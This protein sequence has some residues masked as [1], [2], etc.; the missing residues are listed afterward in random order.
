MFVIWIKGY[1][2]IKMN[3]IIMPSGYKSFDQKKK[4]Q[5]WL[6]GWI[7][8]LTGIGEN[9]LW[10]IKQSFYLLSPLMPQRLETLLFTVVLSVV[11]KIRN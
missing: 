2:H 5:K 8:K 7:N 1:S 4:W 3:D 6:C 10:M 9:V 11:V